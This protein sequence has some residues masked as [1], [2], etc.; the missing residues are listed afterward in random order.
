MAGAD[1]TE[2]MVILLIYVL[3]IRTERGRDGRRGLD[4]AVIKG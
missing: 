2:V 3:I 1:C 4:F